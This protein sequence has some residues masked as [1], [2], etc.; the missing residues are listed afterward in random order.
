MNRFLLI[1]GVLCLLAW[2]VLY[3]STTVSWLHPLTFFG[4]AF[5]ILGFI[6]KRSPDYHIGHN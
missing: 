1:L 5:V 2:G 4:V 6:W 3:F